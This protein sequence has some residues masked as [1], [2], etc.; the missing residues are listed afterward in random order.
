MIF[1]K[2]L[3]FMYFFSMHNQHVSCVLYSMQCTTANTHTFFTSISNSSKSEKLG[4][5]L[6]LI[7]IV[8]QDQTFIKV[9]LIA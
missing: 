6:T 1:A 8:K 9:N 5:F 7:N 3:T 2:Q 4:L